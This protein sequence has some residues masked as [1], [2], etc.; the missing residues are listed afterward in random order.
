M[1][2]VIP[3]I[4]FAKARHKC[5]CHGRKPFAYTDADSR[6]AVEHVKA[7][8]VTEWQKA[9]FNDNRGIVMEASRIAQAESFAVSLTFCFPVTQSLTVGQKNRQIWHLSQHTT[10]P[11]LDN[12]EKFYLDCANGIFWNDDCQVTSMQSIKMYDQNPRTIMEINVCTSNYFPPKAR[13]LLSEF[14]PDSMKMFFCDAAYLSNGAF[15][16]VHAALAP[17]STEKDWAALLSTLELLTMFA[18]RW[19]SAIKKICKIGEIRPCEEFFKNAE[20]I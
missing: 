14:D 19:N 3:G 18:L 4:P 1:K 2:I 8:M 9:I 17:D 12:L 15:E 16:K 20:K 13:Q 7:Q 10:K 11:D 5:G 6:R